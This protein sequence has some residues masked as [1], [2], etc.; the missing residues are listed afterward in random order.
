LSVKIQIQNSNQHK[1]Q[2]QYKNQTQ[3]IIL[4]ENDGLLGQIHTILDPTAATDRSS[5]ILE[6]N[7]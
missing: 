6:T 1:Y 3:K 7:V 4:M 5:V 2:K